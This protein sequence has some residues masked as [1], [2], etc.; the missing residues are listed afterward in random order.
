[1]LEDKAIRGLP[2]AV[3][4]YAGSKVITLVSTV[5]LARLLT[6]ADFGL[7]A[8]S[9]LVINLVG[10]FRDLGLGGGFILR[11]D[12]DARAQGT[13]LTLM[14]GM[15][16]LLAAVV[17]GVSPLAAGW[18]D[19]SRLDSILPV[20]SITLVLGG[21]NW[22]YETLLQRELEF[23]RRFVAV[24]ALTTAQVAVAI[25]LAVAG[26]GVWS[27]VAGW[28]AGWTAQAAALTAL[29]PSRVRPAWDRA[30]AR[31]VLGTS[32][33]FMAQGAL[34]FVQQNADFLAVGRMLG[35]GQLGLYTMAYRL[36]EIPYW[37]I[38]DPAAK[39]T[40]PSFAGM[41]HRGE[42][43]APAFLSVFRLVA[44]VCLPL[45]LLLSAAA[46]PFTRL[47]L[48]DKWLNMIAALSVLGVWAAVRPLE[49]TAGWLLNSLGRAGL[50]AWITGLPLLVAVP[51][52]FMA[53]GEGGILEVAWVIL[54]Y[55]ALTT[56]GIVWAVQRCGVSLQ[57]MW[58][59][60]RP[61]VLAAAPAW[62]AARMVAEATDGAPAAIGLA[63]ATVA[64][65]SV[66]AAAASIAEPGILRRAIPQAGRMLRG[67][68]A[69][70][71]AAAA[72]P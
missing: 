46:E 24:I 41:H 47:L 43:V 65:L 37:A 69:T 72:K 58:R 9:F 60:V 23:R 53:A 54:A 34:A 27:L 25:P 6:P 14:V 31:D 1:M 48:G 40:F 38:A 45:G 55:T 56:A 7:V 68:P 33:G 20:M 66:Y 70:A 61:A 63:A 50:L 17:S 36:A 12:L 49:G 39:V 11:R 4:T 35:A 30:A 62:V 5:V 29:A 59:S 19:E 18:F 8:L 16:A 57:D 26:A 42:P 52:M 28:L 3:M 67:A 10:V 22:F 44:L 71:P 15:G 51:A 64:G 13:V 32:Q 21:F 2:W